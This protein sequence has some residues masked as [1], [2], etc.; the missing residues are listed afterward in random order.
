MER[1]KSQKAFCIRPDTMLLK[2]VDFGNSTLVYESSQEPAFIPEKTST[3]VQKS[4]L[5]HAS[6]YDGRKKASKQLLGIK[7]KLPLVIDHVEGIYLFPIASHLKPDCVWIALSHVK[8]LKKVEKKETEVTFKD[9]QK[10]MVHASI[11]VLFSQM[12]LAIELRK[13]LKMIDHDGIGKKAERK[14]WVNGQKKMIITFSDRKER[15]EETNSKR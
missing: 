6:T 13:R 2:P 10:V 15:E 14:R 1:N 8:S 9:G 7:S 12:H 11:L 4:C 3:I 5:R